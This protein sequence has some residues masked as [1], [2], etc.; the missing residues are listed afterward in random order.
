[1]SSMQVIA[2]ALHK[3]HFIIGNNLNGNI[4]LNNIKGIMPNVIDI[5]V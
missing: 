4:I 2:N 5:L 1:M 3:N